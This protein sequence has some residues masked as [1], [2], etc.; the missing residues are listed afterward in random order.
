MGIHTKQSVSTCSIRLYS[1]FFVKNAVHIN[2]YIFLP[3]ETLLFRFLLIKNNLKINI[4]NLKMMKK[5]YLLIGALCVGAAFVSCVDD[6]ES[7]EVKDLRQLQ[8]SQEKAKLDQTYW[9]KYEAAINNVKQY[10]SDLKDAQQG[11]D[12]IKEG[13][14]NHTSAK[15]AAIA[16]QNMVIA[17]NKKDI[18]DKQAEI[19]AQKAME[20]MTFE[21]I[22]EAKIKANNDKEKAKKALEDYWVAKTNEGYNL[23][24]DSY[25]GAK[26]VD[27]TSASA[28]TSM[29][30]G[31]G[32]GNIKYRNN[33][34]CENEWVKAMNAIYDKEVY[35][36][37]D[38]DGLTKTSSDYDFTFTDDDDDPGSGTYT[39]TSMLSSQTIQLKDNNGY[40]FQTYT[41]YTFKDVKKY[42]KALSEYVKQLS[43]AM[44]DKDNAGYPAAL[45]NLNKYKALQ[46]QI[47]TL[48]DILGDE[49]KAGAY[50]N[51]LKAYEGYA[52][53]IRAFGV[54]VD[55]A[56]AVASV[57]ANSS[58]TNNEATIATLEDA[59]KVYNTAIENAT[60]EINKIE[61]EIVDDATAQ[62]YYED[63]VADLNSQI[64]ANNAV[65]EK[66]RALILNSTSSNTQNTTPAETTAE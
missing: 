41:K 59:I 51:L 8:L 30:L 37:V 18:A 47:T 2:F 60:K 43:D 25:S 28:M 33:K 27:A 38:G 15:E 46:S 56:T 4:L 48:T 23:S 54:Q 9:D 13:N 61:N 63:L 16:Y 31:N 5:S 58:V 45:T 19:A 52:K 40:S 36:Y 20:G 11:L 7:T 17:R 21:Q 66:Y 32:S 39:A 65:A 57:Y 26:T 12:G 64:A 55:Q 3:L 6:S 10:Q 29:L 62:K 35:S 14:L 50:E 49:G 44:P 34:L 24:Y 1:T 53:E 22:A 42:K